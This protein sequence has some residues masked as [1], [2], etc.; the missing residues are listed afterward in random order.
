MSLAEFSVMADFRHG[1]P[2]DRLRAF[3]Q[4]MY[5]HGGE[6][7]DKRL[8]RD[9]AITDRAA[10]NLFAGH[11][12][13]DETF[14][15]IVRRFGR[16]VVRILTEPEIDPILAELAEREA[17]LERELAAARLRRREAEGFVAI[18]EGRRA[19]GLV[20]VDPAQLSLFEARTFNTERPGSR[21]EA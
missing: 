16:D 11:W 10:R 20:E 5:G 18:D 2:R 4:A 8:A 21:Q 6:N 19:G 13:G 15:A 9:L 7:R 1:R 3:L 17:R 14:A 12:P